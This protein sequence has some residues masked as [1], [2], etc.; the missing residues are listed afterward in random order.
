MRILHSVYYRL[1]RMSWRVVRP[2]TLGSRCLVLRGESVLLVR[3]TYQRKYWY[4]P[5][6]GVE[7]GES[8]AAAARRE[9]WEETGLRVGELKLF[10]LYF[11]QREGKNDHVALFVA[12]GAVGEPRATGPE[13]AE[14][15]FFP[16]DALPPDT[17]PATRRRIAEYRGAARAEEW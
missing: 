10:H 1:R 7:R 2:T 14:A 12:E 5:G 11:S 15:A 3:H 4:L 17:S 16:L 9:V 13:I 8:F 6:G